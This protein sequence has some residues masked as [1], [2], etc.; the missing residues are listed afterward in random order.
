MKWY[1]VYWLI[2]WANPM[3]E[4][5]AGVLSGPFKD[6]KSCTEVAKPIFDDMVAINREEKVYWDISVKCLKLPSSTYNATPI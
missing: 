6:L 1:A 4:H 5:Q 3:E 2:L